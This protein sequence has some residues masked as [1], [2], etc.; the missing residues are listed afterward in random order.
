M[1][2]II[3]S[4]ALAA[5]LEKILPIF[6]KEY[7]I[8]YSLN[9]GSSFG[10]ADDSIPSRIKNGE[11][12]DFYFLAEGALLKHAKDGIVNINSK[13]NLVSSNIGVAVKDGGRSFKIVT[14]SSFKQALIDANSIAYAASAS[15]IYLSE[16]VFLSLFPENGSIK[17]K[18]IKILSERV[19]NVLVRGEAEI[20]F[21]QLSE[22]MPIN[23]LSIIGKLPIEIRKS[24]IFSCAIGNNTLHIKEYDQFLGFIK[25]E[26]I[27]KIINN[28]GVEIL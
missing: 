24:F 7:G 21:Q 16:T 18:S 9:Y 2:K 1:L 5:A 22:L 23:G 19:G 15:G 20:G 4:G 14:L 10:E 8:S 6:S 12:F 17:A 28:T 25:Q 13:I 27:V 26:E 3:T 11:S